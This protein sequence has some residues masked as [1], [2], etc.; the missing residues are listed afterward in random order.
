MH[1][2]TTSILQCEVEVVAL[3]PRR[4]VH[5]YPLSTYESVSPLVD[6]DIRVRDLSKMISA[7]YLINLKGEI[8]I[9]RVSHQTPTKNHIE[10]P[11]F[12]HIEMMSAVQQ[13]MLSECRCVYPVLTSKWACMPTTKKFTHELQVLAAKEFRSPVQVFEK[14]SFFH[15][16]YNELLRHLMVSLAASE[17]NFSVSQEF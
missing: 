6:L 11:P 10:P 2:L 13:Q 15:I 1:W 9:Y 8:L 12:R 7:V 3:G 17:G 14:A 16:R 4:L 5:K